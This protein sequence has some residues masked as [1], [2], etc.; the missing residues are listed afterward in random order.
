MEGVQLSGPGGGPID[1]RAMTRGEREKRIAELLMKA[2][3]ASAFIERAQLHS[4]PLLG[5]PSG[6]KMK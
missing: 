1:I 3:G 2:G 5:P 4:A 6:L